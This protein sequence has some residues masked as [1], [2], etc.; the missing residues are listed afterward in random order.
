VLPVNLRELRRML[1]RYGVEVEELQGVKGVTISAE[2]YEIV[3]RDPQV[4][5]LN[6]GQQKVVQIV[7]SSLERVRRETREA[8]RPVVAEEDV[9]FVVEQTGVSREEAARAIAEAGGDVAR[10]IMILQERRSRGS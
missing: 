3:I 10:A 1:K 7:C 9:E 5:I 6:L 4:A 2:D 8:P